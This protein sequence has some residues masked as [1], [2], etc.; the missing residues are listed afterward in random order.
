MNFFV[1]GHREIKM[2]CVWNVKM[3]I[4]VQVVLCVLLK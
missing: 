2:N 3:Q 4:I 1:G